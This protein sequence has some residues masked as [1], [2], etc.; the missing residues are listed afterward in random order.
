MD[1]SAYSWKIGTDFSLSNNISGSHLAF[2]GLNELNEFVEVPTHRHDTEMDLRRVS[3]SFMNSID[4]EW[5]VG[6]TIPYFWKSQE[7]NVSFLEP[8]TPLDVEYAE[9]AGFIHHRNEEYHGFGD[10]E[11]MAGLKKRDLLKEGSI[12][13]I[14][15]GLTLPTGRTEDDPWLLGDLGKKHLHIQFGN[16]TIDPLINFY[17]GFQISEKIG[18]GFYSRA[19]LPF[20]RNTKGFRGAPELAFSPMVNF[21]ISEK[22]SAS[23]GLSAEYFGYSDWRLTGRDPNSGF[24]HSSLSFNLS[25]EMK[26]NLDLGFGF[27]NPIHQSFYGDGEDFEISPSLTFSLRKSF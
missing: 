19:R 15:L 18:L 1:Q 2:Y 14:G 4:E 5:D 6:L 27:T 10:I 25:Y 23:L 8:A 22:L 11:L 26:E 16:G 24:L 20:Y 17:Y 21:T 9:R 3:L 12:M 7:A 13:R